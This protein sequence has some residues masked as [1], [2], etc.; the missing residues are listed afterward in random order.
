MIKARNHP[1]YLR[2]QPDIHVASPEISVI[3]VNWNT[4]LLLGQCL[5]LLIKQ[6]EGLSYDLWVVDNGSTDDSIAMLA[7]S[8][9]QVNIILNGRNVGFAAANNQAMRAAKGRYFLLIN[10]DAFPR[11]NAIQALYYLAELNARCGIVGARLVN[12]DGSFQGSYVDF[13]SLK[14]EFLM[15]TGLGRMLFGPWYPNHVPVEGEGAK[16]VDYVQGACMLVRREAYEQAGG[17]D[18]NYFM[19]SEEV[20]WCYV[21]W[22]SGW[23]IWYQPDAMVTHLGSASSANRVT[24][25]E[26]D[27][28]LSRLRFFKKYHREMATFL[29]Q[30]MI[31][32][33]T[34]LKY[35]LY[36]LLRLVTFKRKGRK[37]VSPVVLL[38]I[39]AKI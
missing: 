8:F 17:L 5:S 4:S 37:V 25:R 26:Y 23:E 27:L 12:V 18:Q 15:L 36:G 6:M 1:S 2:S 38:S 9:P 21:M 28:Y 31:L 19:Y 34:S 33:I 35:L 22:R 39:L 13:P 3:L 11:P 7:R 29:L 20:D 14:Q 32:G 16:V 24:Q 10:T 30:W